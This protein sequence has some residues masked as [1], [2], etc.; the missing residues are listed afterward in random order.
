MQAHAPTAPECRGA[1]AAPSPAPELGIPCWHT[2]PA[3]GALWLCAF[4]PWFYILLLLVVWMDARAQ[5]T[6][7]SSAGR[8][9]P[10]IA[11]MH[12]AHPGGTAPAVLRVLGWALLGPS[13]VRLMALTALIWAGNEWFNRR[14]QGNAPGISCD[15][16]NRKLYVVKVLFC[17]MSREEINGVVFCFFSPKSLY[18]SFNLIF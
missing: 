6:L 8:A 4:A 5:H 12:A 7:C 13:P 17:K 3:A 9:V 2:V 15:I 16:V 11:G 1:S 14:L 18:R 10:R